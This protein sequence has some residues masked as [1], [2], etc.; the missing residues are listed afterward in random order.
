MILVVIFYVAFLP[1]GLVLHLVCIFTAS[2][3]ARGGAKPSG[4]HSSTDVNLPFGVRVGC[5][6]CA[7][8]VTVGTSLTCPHCS[9]RL[10]WPLAEGADREG[11]TPRSQC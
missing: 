10:P 8:T 9:V 7:K 3:A 5:P 2:S 6:S 1:L 11:I 4:T